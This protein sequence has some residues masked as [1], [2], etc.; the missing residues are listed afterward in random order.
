MHDNA[1]QLNIDRDRIILSG[2]SA[3]GQ[4]TLATGLNSREEL[5]ITIKAA[6]RN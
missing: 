2:D 5:G 6:G 4:L 1:D 3:G